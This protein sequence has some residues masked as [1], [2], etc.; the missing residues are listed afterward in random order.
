MT[1]PTPRF[2]I[3]RADGVTE[4]SHPL[5]Y[6]LHRRFRPGGGIHEVYYRAWT[7]WDN[8]ADDHAFI[9]VRDFRFEDEYLRKKDARADLDRYLR[10]IGEIQ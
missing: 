7:V 1:K 10:Q 9:T 6:D 5:C 8:E 2:T 3:D 4:C